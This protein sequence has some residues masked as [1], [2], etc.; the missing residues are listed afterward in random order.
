MKVEKLMNTM[1]YDPVP[2][3]A[4]TVI[5][6]SARFVLLSDR[7]VR[8]EWAEDARFEDRATLAVVNRALPAVKFKRS[9]AKGVLVIRTAAMKLEYRADGKPFSAR[10]LK[11][12]FRLGG[13]TA[14]WRPGLIDKRNLGAT[15]RTL[16][17]LKGGRRKEFRKTADGKW[18]P[19]GRWVKVDLG[20]GLI[21]QSGWALVDDS[22]NVA[23]TKGQE[24]VEPR[25]EGRR[26]DWYLLV[27][28]LDYKAAL[29]DG[30]QVFGRQPVP[31]RYAF[32]YWWSRYWAYTDREIERLV[33]QFDQRRIP[34]DVMVI[35]M[36]WHLEGWTGYT[37]DR[38]YFPDY[39]DFLKWLKSRDLKITLNLHPADGVGRHEEQFPAMAA[40]LGL[41]PARTAK[42]P[43]DITS[44][45]YMDAYFK[46][47]HH[48]MEK[49]GVD[50][51]WMDWQ[52]GE[53]TTMKG[54][55]T[56]PW[57]NHLHWRDM[58]ARAG[59]TGRRPLIFSR[60]GG[61]GAGR[62]CIGF[63][64]DTYS[65]W[66][67]LQ[68]QPYFTATASNV[69]YGYWS[70]DIGG[71]MFGPIEP[72]LY[73]RWLQFGIY[74]PV[75]RT[76]TSKN[77]LGERRVWAYPDPYGDIMEDAIRTRYE[78]V[79]YIYTESRRCFDTAVSL[80]RPMYYD[81]PDCTAA[82]KATGQY[83]FGDS[84]LV[85][86]VVTRAGESAELTETSIWLPD[87]DWFDTARGCFEKGGRT[88]KRSYLI[89]EI[90][91]FV[92][93]GTVLPGQC[94][95]LRLRE[96]SYR[97]LLL[98]AYPGG[99]GEYSLYEDDG[100]STGYQNQECARIGFS[101]KITRTGRIIRVK[102][103]NGR[104]RGFE[105]RR[106]L[107]IRLPGSVPPAR[108]CAG[109][110]E[111]KYSYRSG[112]A[113]GWTYDGQTATTVIRMPVIDV[114]KDTV[115]TVVHAG[116]QQGKMADGLKGALARL[117]RVGYHA[118]LA[119]DLLILHPEERMSVEAAQTGN[120]ISRDP[121]RFEAEIRQLRKLLRKLPSVLKALITATNSW[122]PDIKPE[123]K[124]YCDKALALLKSIEQ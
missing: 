116:N 68:Y 88:I 35:D 24:W 19:T 26:I 64:G 69:L 102:A 38:R 59:R 81:Y 112:S 22:S 123:R 70:H 120:R 42:V 56:L 119:L 60:F 84:L 29:R 30:A 66:E 77:P 104:Y 100:V 115:V 39:R 10:N 105:K 7:M 107:E 6:G 122:S 5:E 83:M 91:V 9:T 73:T 44:R 58:E 71:H 45:K 87:G 3:P 110:T 13:K 67:S 74:S 12:S 55:D 16:D 79:P 25:P 31:P 33:Q 47:L 94:N 118:G 50:F 101:Q 89:S 21:S 111:L 75:V 49:E 92:R 99:D 27:H 14:Y 43:F 46:I 96:G 48:P 109:R 62:Y 106:S 86:P 90:P 72:E 57:I 17:Q 78:L 4:N 52:Q 40:A 15:I 108:V 121:S 124:V 41:N 18:V 53:S 95:Q 65:D 113:A 103:A 80:C 20:K 36:D 28:G 82:Y 23:I 37:W 51:W 97:E 114:T 76:H 11:V 61:L 1:T 98:T 93:P 34:L 54:L 2:S 8:L 32:G 85:A 117:E 63:S